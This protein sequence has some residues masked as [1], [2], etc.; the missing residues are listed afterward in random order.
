MEIVSV[1]PARQFQVTW[2]KPGLFP[3]RVTVK[4]RSFAAGGTPSAWRTDTYVQSVTVD[5]LAPASSG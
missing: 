3:V 5:V 2:N 4:V 1:E